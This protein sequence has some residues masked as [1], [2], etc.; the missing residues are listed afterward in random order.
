MLVWEEKIVCKLFFSSEIFAGFELGTCKQEELVS[1]A[2]L[3]GLCGEATDSTFGSRFQR[4]RG[5]SEYK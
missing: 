5:R 4:E 3:R 2:G 1:V